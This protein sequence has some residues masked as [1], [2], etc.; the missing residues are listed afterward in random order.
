[1]ENQQLF[2]KEINEI[3]PP[4]KSIKYAE[5]IIKI[6]KDINEE[7]AMLNKRQDLYLIKSTR[8]S[9][10]RRCVLFFYK[11]VDGLGRHFKT[12]IL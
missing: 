2:F 6:R 1:M 3:L 8:S 4:P 9:E 5:D 10:Y 11:Y 7:M 12:F